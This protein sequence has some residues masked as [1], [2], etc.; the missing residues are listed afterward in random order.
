MNTVHCFLGFLS[1]VG[2]SGLSVLGLIYFL[3]ILVV[4]FWKLQSFV[5]G[6]MVLQSQDLVCF[7]MGTGF[8]LLICQLSLES[9]SRVISISTMLLFLKLFRS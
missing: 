2:L 8:L 3:E 5:V 6:R 1:E 4:G 7:S 9:F